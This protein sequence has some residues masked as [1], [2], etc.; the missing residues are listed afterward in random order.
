MDE[1][2]KKVK[3]KLEQ[4]GYI[5]YNINTTSATDEYCIMTDGMMIF[6]NGI[7]KSLTISFDCKSLP[8]DV[9]R[10]MMV[11]NEVSETRAVY[12]SESYYLDKKNKNYIMGEKAKK[13]AIKEMTDLAL[14]EMAKDQIYSHILATQKCHEC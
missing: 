11:L 4:Y 13:M 7:E 9:A 6:S 12:I 1:F 14:R 2:G 10:N 5:I 3:A 8:E